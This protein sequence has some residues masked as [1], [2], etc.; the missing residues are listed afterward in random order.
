[1]NLFFVEMAQ[2]LSD[3][4]K[5][6]E[7]KFA[8]FQNFRKLIIHQQINFMW[9]PKVDRCACK[10]RHTA[11]IETLFVLSS[12][13]SRLKGRLNFWT[14]MLIVLC[15][16]NL[17]LCSAEI[18]ASIRF[19]QLSQMILLKYELDRCYKI[20]MESERDSKLDR[21][22]HISSSLVTTMNVNK[23]KSSS[24]INKWYFFT[25]FKFNKLMNS[26]YINM[27]KWFGRKHL[28]WIRFSGG[29][30]CF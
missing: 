13:K 11:K 19:I 29:F 1:M 15:L 12:K 17:Q 21:C 27:D 18:I 9:T 2:N 10:S 4:H 25:L 28:Y 23:L 6:I 30:Q 5:Y 7:K 26:L 3:L 24:F 16:K 22:K 14:S 20:K 8:I